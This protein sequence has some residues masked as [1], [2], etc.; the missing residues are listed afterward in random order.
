MIHKYLDDTDRKYLG[1]DIK[2]EDINGDKEYEFKYKGIS[3]YL[4][5]YFT[6]YTSF[7][8]G[9]FEKIKHCIERFIDYIPTP[10]RK[11]LNIIIV[12]TVFKKEFPADNV[13]NSQNANN[14]FTTLFRKTG[15]KE[16]FIYRKEDMYKV[17]IHEMIHYFD[18]DLKGKYR[19]QNNE[20]ILLLN[21]FVDDTNLIDMNEAYTETLAVYLYIV[22]TNKES[23]KLGSELERY[24]V[25][26]IRIMNGLAMYAH[27]NGRENVQKSH[28]YSYYVCRAVLFDHLDEFLN[29]VRIKNETE[30]T[31]QVLDMMMNIM[32]DKKL[33]H[34]YAGYEPLQT[35]KSVSTN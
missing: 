1:V 29:I 20:N 35:M 3:T 21:M 22:F 31:K 24:R 12:P 25:R 27:N 4:V 8:V 34:K 9:M 19:I 18:R 16:I 14:G 17:L 15:R 32:H 30:N 5:F 10:D 28:V 2:S 23:G 33:K 6:S 11:E 26:F 13:F 7:D